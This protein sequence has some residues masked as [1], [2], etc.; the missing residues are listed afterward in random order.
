M[1]QRAGGEE[2]IAS[3]A[4]E[5][6]LRAGDTLLIVGKAENNERLIDEQALTPRTASPRNQ[7]RWLWELGGAAVLVHPESRLI[8][9]SLRDAEFRT[10]YGLDVFGIRRNGEAVAD[11]TDL[12]LV[13]SDSLLVVGPW[14]RIQQL[15]S[16]NHDFVV[17]EIPVEQADVVPAYRR[18]PV[19][20]IILAAMVLLSVFDVVPLVAAVIMAA[21][22]AVF[23]RCLT[24]EGSYRAIHWSSLVMVAGMLPLA[25]ALKQTG[26]T[27]IVVDALMDG[28]GGAGPRAMF[29]AIFLLTA[30]VGLFLS[31][32]AAAVLVA[33]IA[34]FAAEAVGVSPYPFAVAVIIAASAAY[35]TPVS[36]PVVTL[37][38]EPGRYRFMD[39]VKAGLPLLV[40]TYLV[41]LIVAPLV[42]PFSPH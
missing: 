10:R 12:K 31:N 24:M 16:R 20:L 28:V 7:Q 13:A 8:G 39:F 1:R 17:M 6:E 29:T 42:F 38:V 25:D 26:G 14:P 21:L 11:Y 22:A 33:P 30:A 4:P 18:M 23:S 35:V 34:I 36:T 15:Q 27:T 2:R 37:V 40:L 41:T 9:K 19:A 32:T 3:P 5:T